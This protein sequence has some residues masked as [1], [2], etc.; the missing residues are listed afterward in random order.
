MKEISIVLFGIGKV[1]KTLID[2]LLAAT[3]EW[4][5]EGVKLRIPVIANS[6][7]ALFAAEGISETWQED[8]RKDGKNLPISGYH[9]IC[10]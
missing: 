8:F 5:S 2:Q 7:T 6:E 10:F 1:G 4:Q 3:E 9:S